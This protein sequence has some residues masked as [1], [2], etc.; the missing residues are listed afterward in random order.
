MAERVVCLLA[1][2]AL[3]FGI[4]CSARMAQADAFFHLDTP[5]SLAE[6]VRME[7]GNAGYH[8][9][10]AEHLESTGADPKRERET[11]ALLSPLDA[12]YWIDLGVLAE[13]NSD[14]TAAERYYLKAAS[15]SRMFAPR[16]ALMNFYFRRQ[17]PAAFWHWTRESLPVSYGDIS[18]IFRL[19]WRM[20]DDPESIRR[21]LPW[22]DFT[23][24]RYLTFLLDDG[25]SEAAPP[26]AR[27][28]ADRATAEDVNLLLDYCGRAMTKNVGSAMEVWNILSRRK[29]EPFT[30]LAPQ[31]GA[32]VTNGDF[33]TAPI[34]RGFDWHFSRAD[35]VSVTMGGASGVFVELTG[36]QPQAVTIMNEWIPVEKDRSYRIDFRYNSGVEGSPGT[37]QASGL[38]WQIE[39]PVS[40]AVPAR[41][42]DLKPAMTDASDHVDFKA[43]ENGA[44]MLSLTYERAPGTVRHA[45]KFTIQGI[46]A[47]LRP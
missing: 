20:T 25:H 5:D 26:V 18:Q 29:K 19:C 37:S 24:S 9:L 11:A 1:L 27:E 3:A 43:E 6:A 39:N 23:R 12:E 40:G 32:I 2:P 4:Y 14:F 7:S 17:Q 22:T 46:S 16:W 28:L 21:Q 44:A 33:R 41:S 47:R 10:Y 45:E 34:E 13:V 15:V 31:E 8:Q 38:A 42:G 36:D 35:G 30:Q